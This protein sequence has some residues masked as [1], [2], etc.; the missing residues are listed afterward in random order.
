[1]IILIGEAPGRES[2]A[3]RPSLA[4]TGSSGRNL[5]RIAGWEWTDYL[6]YTARY[7]LFL[8]PQ[9]RW[10]DLEAQRR[11]AKIEGLPLGG[12]RVLLLGTKVAAAFHFGMIPLYTW[13]HEDW[14]D[15]AR[16]PHPSGLNRMWNSPAELARARAFLGPLL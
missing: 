9:P 10:D 11:A 2:I 4:L 8:D 1:M 12:H 15:V 16:V 3:A 13:S 14:A 5:C 6:R 7:N